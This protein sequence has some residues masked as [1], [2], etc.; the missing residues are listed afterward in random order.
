MT[1][2]TNRRGK[3]CVL[4]HATRQWATAGLVE[5]R[6]YQLYLDL[7]RASGEEAGLRVWVYCLMPNHVHLIVVPERAT[8]MAQAIGWTSADYA[9]YY[10]LRQRRC[11]HV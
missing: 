9:R 7:V 2:R 8:A 6:D 5:D 4:C 3:G 1:N 10:N 11:G